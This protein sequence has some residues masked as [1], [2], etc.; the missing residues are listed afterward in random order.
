MRRWKKKKKQDEE[1]DDD[2]LS[3]DDMD[4]DEEEDESPRRRSYLPPR[5]IR[6]Y[7]HTEMDDDLDEEEGATFEDLEPKIRAGKYK[8]KKSD[9]WN[10]HILYNLLKERGAI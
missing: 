2:L 10:A 5:P 1:D 9:P 8:P 4:D 7:H 6:T 3:F